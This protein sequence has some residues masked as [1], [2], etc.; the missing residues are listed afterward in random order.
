MGTLQS[1]LPE[2]ACPQA[3]AE[4]QPSQSTWIPNEVMNCTAVNQRKLLQ[5]PLQNNQEES[6]NES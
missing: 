6:M 4:Q 2:I 3:M 5:Y 1:A